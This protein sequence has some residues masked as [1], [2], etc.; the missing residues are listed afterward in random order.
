MPRHAL[1]LCACLPLVGCAVFGPY[2]TGPEGMTGFD[3]DL[4]RLA[5][6][7]EFERALELTE[8]GAGGAAG[9]DLLR[10]LHR[11][12][13]LRY[14]GEHAE[15]NRLLQEAELEIDERYTRSVS[16]AAL[17]L[18]ANDRILAYRPPRVERLMV[19]YYGALN[20]LALR[21]PDE[22][23]VEAR[24][25]AAL[26]DGSEEMEFDP[27]ETHLRRA[28]RYFTGAVFEAAREWNDAEV[29]YRNAWIGWDPAAPPIDPD[30]LT[31]GGQLAR[32]LVGI[33]PARLDRSAP[34]GTD[35]AEVVLIL[36]SG[37]IAHRVQRSAA[38]PIYRRDRDAFGS[39]DEGATYDAGLCVAARVL[40]ASYV[41]DRASR[42]YRPRGSSL[43]VVTAA[44]PA[45]Q[46]RSDGVTGGRLSAR[47]PDPA[48]PLASLPASGPETAV[49][50]D[51]VPL[52]L[53]LDLSS[54]YA[55]EFEGRLGGTVAKAVARAATKY[56]VV[57]ATKKAV[58]EEDETLGDVVGL[59]GNVA[60]IASEHADLRS[61][62]LLPGALRIARIRVPA[63]PVELSVVLDQAGPA[64]T[65]IIPLGSLS[66]AAGSVAVVDARVWP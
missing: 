22:A 46:G 7:G 65:R 47:G 28:L 39:G 52:G 29:A 59:L 6:A 21:E 42:C 24:R 55:A 51:S 37:F 38:V 2:G 10:L 64:A 19:H 14:A 54:A 43:F 40:G 32:A 66:V 23:A 8:E 12:A 56:L 33:T 63:G 17:S 4:R 5:R 18:L 44:W 41:G 16:R 15:S 62:H 53:T 27:G 11:A 1:W 36:E 31:G 49:W 13:V 57:E 58:K 3:T 25:L 50:A 61:W 30:T 45:L 26:L 34:L 9:D 20:Y 48:G 35:S 60:A